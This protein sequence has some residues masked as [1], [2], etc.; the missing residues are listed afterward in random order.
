M[1]SV[2]VNGGMQSRLNRSAFSSAYKPR[3]SPAIPVPMN[4]ASPTSLPS[5]PPLAATGSGELGV[6]GLVGGL[7][8][9]IVSLG[10]PPGIR[11][12]PLLSVGTRIS[13][14]P[15]SSTFAMN[16]ALA[17]LTETFRNFSDAV[18]W[19][20]TGL[21]S[22]IVTLNSDAS[23]FGEFLSFVLWSISTVRLLPHE[24]GLDASSRRFSPG[25]S[26]DAG[27]TGADGM[28]AR[29]VAAPFVTRTITALLPPFR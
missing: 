11:Y 12:L 29:A 28:V 20:V 5:V 24:P 8:T 22:K 2:D 6:G 1:S 17:G 19:F 13:A 25:G 10:R 16:R 15:C 18:T 27:L 3:L 4:C 9:V 23:G 26:G 21:V 14:E 7:T